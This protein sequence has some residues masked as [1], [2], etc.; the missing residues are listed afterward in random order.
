MTDTSAPPSL[1][2]P[3][4]PRLVRG[5]SEE[6]DSPRMRLLDGSLVSVDISGF[7]AL[8]ERLQTK[9]KAGAEELVTRISDVFDALI[10][11]AERHGGD[12]LKFRGDALLLLFTGERH[13][14]RA[15]GAASDMQWTIE[16]V[17]SAESSVGPVELRMSAGVHSGPCHFFLTREPHR[18]LLVAGP[19]ATHVFELEDLAGAGE[20]VVSADTAAALDPGWLGDERDGARLMTRL[21]SGASAIPPPPAVA[22]YRPDRVRARPAP[23]PSRRRERRGRA[24]PGDGGVPQAARHGRAAGERG[25]RDA[26]R[27]ARRGR[28]RRAKGMR[29]VR[30]DMARVRH[31]RRS[32]EAVPHRRRP[33]ELR[34][35]RGRHAACAARRAR[36]MPRPRPARRRAPR[37]RLHGRHRQSRDGARTR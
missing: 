7:T 17:G 21:D 28:G 33:L 9:G 15:C 4:L 14:E 8:A 32:G 34:R 11:V 10:A 3:Y 20:I 23:R 31:R 29:H 16:R 19:A 22:G 24:S 25:I 1:L 12:V 18:E 36:G 6:P 5:W 2:A 27:P 13:A 26:A 30:T 37:P 35:R